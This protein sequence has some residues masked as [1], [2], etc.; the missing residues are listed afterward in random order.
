M[1]LPRATWASFDIK[2]RELELRKRTP[3]TPRMLRLTLGG[4]GMAGF[5]S[6][7]AD[8]HVKLVF[9]DRDTGVTRPP[10]QDGDH[11]DWPD[12]MPP[13][14]DC[15]VRRYDRAAG[16]IDLDV[17]LHDVGLAATW[18]RTAPLGSSIWVAGPRPG[19]V[20]PPAFGFH[21]LL[22]DETA[23]PAIARWLSELAPSTRAV[24]AIEVADADEEQ[25]IECHDGAQLTWLHRNGA[26]A[27]STDLLGRYVE[28]VT[29]P[30]DTHT[31]LWAAGE[32]GC[33]KP[34]R[35]WARAHGLGKD[36]SDISGYWR[37]GAA[38][39]APES[40]GERAR[41]AVA[42]LLGRDH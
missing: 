42:H 28:S 11:L 7:L 32:A 2:I 39:D 24:A 26:P 38:Q 41:H 1:T 3:I 20:V 35:R 23:L 37:R 18:A 36:Q 10:T 13:V 21:V 19:R 40:L 16:E 27:G 6:H 31:Y 14:R 22:G 9:P 25:P 34:V 5:E 15:S 17:V 29:L 12:P 30:S 4:P 33:L 8:E